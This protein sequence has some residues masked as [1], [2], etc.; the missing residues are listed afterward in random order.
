MGTDRILPA[1]L[2][3]IVLT[4]HPG[5]LV[6]QRILYEE[7][8]SDGSPDLE[9]HSAWYDSTGAPLTPMTVDSV[10]GNPGGDG[11]IGFVEGDTAD[12]GGLGMAW[13]GSFSLADYSLKSS[14]YIAP[15]SSL[16]NS[17]I[18]RTD[19]TGGVY[20]CYHLTASFFPSFGIERLRFRYW[21]SNPEL[22]ETIAEWQGTDIPGG[23]PTDPGWHTME[24]RAEGHF[25]W[26]Y[27]D[28]QK[29]PGSPFYDSRID[30][31]A[32]GIYVFSPFGSSRTIVDDII[33]RG[34]P[35]SHRV[36]V[37]SPPPLL[38][39]LS[40]ESWIGEP[41]DTLFYTASVT[42]TTDSLLS[43]QAWSE[44]RNPEGEIMSPINGPFPLSLEANESLSA[45]LFLPIP[46]FIPDNDKFPYLFR[47]LLGT[48]PSEIFD[49]DQIRLVLFLK[50][51]E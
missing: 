11:W 51:E 5:G 49:Q 29:L 31:G 20:K 50:K 14:V 16:Y 13:A 19:S 6:A 36:P 32:F 1:C 25:F 48:F 17:I 45:D 22:I 41:G 43:F 3:A 18:V 7:R 8:F 40:P 30:T 23:P 26:L 35:D 34:M 15:D 12:L 28:N 37:Y 21:H 9:W 24:I 42:N 46:E 39:A 44:G 4:F 33:V 10:G 27:W 2:F 47:V 38:I